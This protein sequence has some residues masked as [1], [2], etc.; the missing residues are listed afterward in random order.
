MSLV[1]WKAIWYC[2]AEKISIQFV[3]QSWI[4]SRSFNSPLINAECICVQICRHFNMNCPRRNTSAKTVSSNSSHASRRLD[5]SNPPQ[6]MWR[7]C[8]G[9]TRLGGRWAI[10]CKGR[11]KQCR[12]DTL[13]EFSMRDSI[14]TNDPEFLT[15][16][17]KNLFPSPVTT[18]FMKVFQ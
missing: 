17:W 8:S 6:W 1:C 9:F 14:A 16:V 4:A 15:K 12:Q 3:L 5:Q 13:F 11:P 18:L 2:F 10:C 7:R